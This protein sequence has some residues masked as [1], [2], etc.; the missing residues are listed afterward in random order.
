MWR[1]EQG[2]LR[3]GSVK[4]S[5]VLRLLSSPAPA[6]ACN[7]YFSPPFCLRQDPVGSG[8]SRPGGQ[9]RENA[10]ESGSD[11]KADRMQGGEE[12]KWTLET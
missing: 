9:G 5:F 4:A 3:P 2:A 8:G 6:K 7:S 1:A 10:P 12:G 11:Q